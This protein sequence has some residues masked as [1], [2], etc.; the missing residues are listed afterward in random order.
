MINKKIL[1]IGGSGFFGSYVS[2][3]LCDLIGKKNITIIGRTNRTWHSDKIKKNISYIDLVKFNFSKFKNFDCVIHCAGLHSEK[4]KT[5]N[6]YY[7]INSL[8][9]KKILENIK[10]KK[11]IYISTLSVL[12]NNKTYK[13]LS[14]PSNTYALSKYISEKLIEFHSRNSKSQFIILRY[15]T[16]IGKNSK[17]N[18][19][20]YIYNQCKKNNDIE[21]FSNDGLKRN[22]IH[23]S[24]AFNPL[25]KLIN[26]KV[27]K[28]NYELFNIASSNSMSLRDIINLIKNHTFSKSKNKNY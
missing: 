13:H 11:L 7:N 3:K 24:N 2:E 22:F 10:F 27:F 6:Q 23:I 18:L 9:T 25:K 16:I 8:I 21:I 17:L 20:D 19:V 12:S 26:K 5:W 15:P 28:S 1:V 4:N 14:D